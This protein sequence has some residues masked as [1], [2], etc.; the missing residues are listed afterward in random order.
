VKNAWVAVLVCGL[1][2]TGAGAAFAKEDAA[3]AVAAKGQM[4]IAANG[5]RLGTVYRVDSDGAVQMIIGGK[6]VTVPASTLSIVDGRLVTSLSK[7][8]IL[9][10]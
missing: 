8:Q 5:A 1:M 2:L 10:L 6:M 7:N 3:A 4:L 9:A